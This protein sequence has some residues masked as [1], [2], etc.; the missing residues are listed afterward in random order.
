MPDVEPR[1]DGGDHSCQ[2]AVPI[3]QLGY[4]TSSGRSGTKRSRRQIQK[5]TPRDIVVI[6]DKHHWALTVNSNPLI[7]L[8]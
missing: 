1:I 5:I 4:G 3:A 7:V 6:L 2:F 8:L